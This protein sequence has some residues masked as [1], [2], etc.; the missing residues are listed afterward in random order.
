M[1][2]NKEKIEHILTKYP[3]T[4]FSRAMFFQRF[5]QNYVIGWEA[6][7]LMWDQFHRFWAEEASLERAL[8]DV[9]KQTAFQLPPEADAKRYKKANEFKEWKKKMPK[10]ERENFN[11]ALGK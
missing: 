2:T 7:Y 1:E 10:E 6:P 4:K 11:L 9:L 5:I 3:E 8:R